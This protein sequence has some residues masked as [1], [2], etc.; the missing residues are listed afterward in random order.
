LRI[1]QPICLGIEQGVQRFLHGPT[2][3]PIEVALD[4]LIA[5]FSDP[6]DCM[7]A[8]MAESGIASMSTAW[9]GM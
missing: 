1:A 9:L 2:H 8:R 7:F 5:D 4:P 6:L 3:H